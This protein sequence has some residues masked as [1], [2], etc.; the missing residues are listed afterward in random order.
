MPTQVLIIYIKVFAFLIGSG[1]I[2]GA[3]SAHLLSKY[4]AKEQLSVFETAVFYQITQALGGLLLVVL[5]MTGFVN[6]K[7]VLLSAQLILFG[8]LVF[9]GSLYLLCITGQKW[10]GAITPL[11]GLSL[12]AGW[13]LLLTI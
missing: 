10:L 3:L 4:F 12:I 9:S 6:Y 8:I 2:S 5:C 1:V 13:L 11:G 7:R